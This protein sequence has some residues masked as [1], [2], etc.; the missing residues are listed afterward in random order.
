MGE[1][2]EKSRKHEIE[3]YAER[4]KECV[5][6]LIP[7]QQL[8]LIHMIAHDKENTYSLCQVYEI[9]M[10][11]RFIPHKSRTQADAQQQM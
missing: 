4:H 5:H 6:R 8:S 2:N 1:G 10:L 7:V 3:R 11:F 9:Q